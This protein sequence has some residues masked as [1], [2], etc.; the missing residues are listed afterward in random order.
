M[1]EKE[2]IIC[3][4]CGEK[5]ARYRNPFPTVDIIIEYAGGIILVSRKN[6]PH[7]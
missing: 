1:S 3:P 4:N 7:G 6:P 2:I 5:I